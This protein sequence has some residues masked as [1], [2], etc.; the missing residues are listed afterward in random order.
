MGYRINQISVTLSKELEAFWYNEGPFR[1]QA[2]SMETAETYWHR[3]PDIGVLKGL[4]LRIVTLRSSSANVE[5]LF[6]QMKTI[7]APNRHRFSLDTLKHMARARVSRNWDSFEGDD[8]ENDVPI[9]PSPTPSQPALSC[10]VDL[11]PGSSAYVRNL[12]SPN[13]GALDTDDSCSTPSSSRSIDISGKASKSRKEPHHLRKKLSSDELKAS[14]KEFFKISDFKIVNE[15]VVLEKE[16]TSQDLYPDIQAAI[17]SFK[18]S[19]KNRKR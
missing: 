12:Y 2:D 14:Y 13:V 4:A 19:I 8:E 17:S 10:S 3:Q 1:T 15:V 9:K 11:E 16:E 7:Q 6:S 18:N 5:R